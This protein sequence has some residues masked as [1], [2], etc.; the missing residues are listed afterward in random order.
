MESVTGKREVE[1]TAGLR[2]Q[3]R[4]RKEIEMGVV[5]KGWRVGT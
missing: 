5:W 1:D 4:P 3:Q 2:I